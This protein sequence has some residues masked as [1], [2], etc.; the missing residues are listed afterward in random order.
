ITLTQA[1]AILKA[2]ALRDSSGMLK[3]SVSIR[4][5]AGNY[6]LSGT[7]SLDAASSGSSEHPVSIEGPKDAT[8][9][10][11]GGRPVNG[12][13]PV[14]DRAALAR[15]PMAARTHVLQANLTGQGIS[16]YGQYSRRGFGRTNISA[17]LEVFY[18]AQPMPLARWPN[19]GYGFAK[20]AATPGGAN[21]R[22]FT[23]QERA[24]LTAWMGEPNLLA[25]GYWF[26]YWADETTPIEAIDPATGQFTL[27]LPTPGYG[28]KSGQPVFFQNI[29]AELD[30]PG[31]WYLDRKSGVL[32]FWPPQPLHENEVEVSMLDKLVAFVGP[33]YI[34]ISGVTF[35][36]ARG[37]AITVDSGSQHIAITNSV[38]RNIGNHAAVI[39]GHDNGVADML[40]ENAGEGGV[41]LAGGDRKTLTAA[42]LYVERSTIR[43]FGRLTRTIQPGVLISGVG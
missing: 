34:R 15:L 19:T 20:I 1:L 9:I 21:G 42:N 8:A 25:T 10:I 2:P 3:E 23:V 33:S 18:R 16:D 38:I 24:N 39:Y 17:A 27:P 22:T 26:N 28:L 7:L 14:T 4:L 5:A 35:E 36:N 6:R 41:V 32:Y 29:L 43:R 37:N 13:T 30:Q 11:S 12:F 40:I 31:E